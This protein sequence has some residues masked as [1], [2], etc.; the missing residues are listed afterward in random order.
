MQGVVDKMATRVAKAAGVGRKTARAVMAA[1]W[2]MALRA[3]AEARDGGGDKAI[4]LHGVGRLWGV[5]G[6]TRR[7]NN[8]RS[9][10]ET[11]ENQAEVRHGR[12][13]GG[14]V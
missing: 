4:W 14:Q 9:N 10:A 12:D 1:Y 11:E 2:R 8:K 13:D 3:M 6:G 5:N 7:F